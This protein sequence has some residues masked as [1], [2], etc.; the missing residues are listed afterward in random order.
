MHVVHGIAKALFVN[1]KDCTVHVSARRA[2]LALAEDTRGEI[3]PTR[4][5]K[6]DDVLL[7]FF[8]DVVD[9]FSDRRPIASVNGCCASHVR[10]KANISVES[11][12]TCERAII[13]G[14]ARMNEGR[15]PPGVRRRQGRRTVYS[16]SVWATTRRLPV[17][18][19]AT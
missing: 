10:K 12:R 11:A 3:R 4:D 7:I 17:R 18:G 15:A 6:L 8:C 19:P 16:I 2:T 13:A 5:N 1:R 9:I 14:R